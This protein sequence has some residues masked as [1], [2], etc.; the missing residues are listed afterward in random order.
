MGEAIWV[1]MGFV[2][3]RLSFAI[4][5]DSMLCVRGARVKWINFSPID[6][7]YCTLMKLIFIAV[8]V[9]LG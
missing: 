7:A 3:A 1:V 2:R 5:R 9:G 8:G 6:V 4:L